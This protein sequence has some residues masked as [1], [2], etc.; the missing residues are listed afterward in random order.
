MSAPDPEGFSILSK[1]LA[2]G[3]VLAGPVYG[4]IK[5][6]NAKAD[7]QEV[8]DA[9]EKVDAELTILRG[10]QAKIFDKISDNEKAARDR[11]DEMMKAVYQK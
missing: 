6:Y 4:F 5:L 1:V 10:T 11:H 8:K 7:K 3:A 2:A 9:F